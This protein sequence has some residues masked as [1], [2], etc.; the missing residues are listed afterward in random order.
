MSNNSS[1][2]IRVSITED[3]GPTRALVVDR[4]NGA[5][6]F[7][8]VGDW[9]DAETTL[10]QLPIVKPD[11]ALV[12]VQLRTSNGIAVIR[13]LKPVLPATQFVILTVCKDSDHIHDALAAGATG[14]LL[15]STPQDQLLADIREVHEGGSPMSG[16]IAR[17]I[18]QFFIVPAAPSVGAEKLSPR[19]EEVLQL[20]SQGLY[21][22]E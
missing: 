5:P 3:D 11:V 12:D 20:I 17:K 19:E 22:K 13:R 14:Y 1:L 15:K 9:A 2:P 18:V 7:Q 16:E 10:R 8:V 21:F 6:G 4:L